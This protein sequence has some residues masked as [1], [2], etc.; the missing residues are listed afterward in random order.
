MRPKWASTLAINE[1][2][3][4]PGLTHESNIGQIISECGILKGLAVM[5]L[6]CVTVPV[7]QYVQVNIFFIENGLKQGGILLLLCNF[8]VKY[9]IK[10][11]TEDQDR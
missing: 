3:E 9:I 5:V 1:Y 6:K 4:Q 10:N 2:Q 11:V 8:A 7:W